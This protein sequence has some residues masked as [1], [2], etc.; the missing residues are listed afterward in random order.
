[1]SSK[2]TPK[3][4]SCRSCR[5]GKGSKRGNAMMKQNERAFRHAQKVAIN[6]SSGMYDVAPIGNYFD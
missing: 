6:K 4:C 5:R 1:M 2:G 3:S